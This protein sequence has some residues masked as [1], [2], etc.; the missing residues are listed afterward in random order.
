M[1]NNSVRSA[2]LNA[3]VG[4]KVKL[5]KGSHRGERGVIK[6]LDGEKLSIQI[7]GSDKVVIALPGAVT[8]YSLAARKAWKTEPNRS[9]GRRKGTK[10]TDRVSVTLRIDRELWELFLKK[11]ETGAIEDRTA[12]VNEWFREK[13]SELDRAESQT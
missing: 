7:D 4:D 5:K 8:N 11:E 1:A 9:V 2:A 12:A 10:L 6:A 13:L 3:K